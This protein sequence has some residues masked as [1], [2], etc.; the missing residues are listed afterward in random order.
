MKMM[1]KHRSPA[2]CSRNVNIIFRRTKN[3]HQIIY[4]FIEHFQFVCG[5]SI[6]TFCSF[7][8]FAWFSLTC[9]R[10]RNVS[11]ISN[12]VNDSL[13]LINIDEVFPLLHFSSHV[14]GFWDFLLP[15]G[16][17]TDELNEF[18]EIIEVHKITINVANQRGKATTF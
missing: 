10:K 1:F 6:E 15:H 7:L 8:A 4:L 18:I 5:Y 13:C 17:Y 14:I 16:S 11:W 12:Q 3:Q 2:N 9:K